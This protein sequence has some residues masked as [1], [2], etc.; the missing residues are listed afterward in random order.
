LS[1][2]L[3]RPQAVTGDE[4]ERLRHLHH[5]MRDLRTRLYQCATTPLV[6]KLEKILILLQAAG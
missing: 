3:V 2:L 6:H 1:L 4:S 5:S